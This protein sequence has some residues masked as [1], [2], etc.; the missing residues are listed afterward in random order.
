[1]A[2]L[3]LELELTPLEIT[4]LKVYCLAEESSDPQAAASE[5]EQQLRLVMNTM[6]SAQPSL[7]LI[8]L[9][10]GEDGY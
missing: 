9:G 4:S 6:Q 8:L 10:L 3:H 2:V 7:Y 1:M 5:Y